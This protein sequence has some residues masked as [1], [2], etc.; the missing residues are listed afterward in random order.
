ML[1][2]PDYVR[3]CIQ[4][5]ST[6]SELDL[7]LLGIR[8]GHARKMMLHLPALY[9]LAAAARPTSTLA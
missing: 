9:A 8:G 2:H 3:L 1:P 5:I 6:F 7:Q 4:V